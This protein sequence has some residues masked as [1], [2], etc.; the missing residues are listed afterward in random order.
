MIL[1]RVA[2]TLI[3]DFAVLNHRVLQK[4]FFEVS[5]KTAP[6]LPVQCLPDFETVFD[7]VFLYSGVIMQ[8]MT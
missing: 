7:A 2:S 3:L 6:C 8:I 1:A 5:Q 4:R